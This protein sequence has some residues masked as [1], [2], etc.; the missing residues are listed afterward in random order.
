MYSLR[1]ICHPLKLKILPGFSLLEVGTSSFHLSVLFASP[2]SVYVR[3]VS[4]WSSLFFGRPLV[5]SVALWLSVWLRIS[6]SDFSMRESMCC[7]HF[8]I[9]AFDSADS[10]MSH[11]V[12]GVVLRCHPRNKSA[13]THSQCVSWFGVHRSRRE[14]RWCNST[15]VCGKVPHL[16]AAMFKYLFRTSTIWFCH[17]APKM[18]DGQCLI[19][20]VV[21][22]RTSRFQSW[23]GVKD[24]SGEQREHRLAFCRES[25]YGCS[26]LFAGE[27]LLKTGKESVLA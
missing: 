22:Y 10:G 3:S 18:L 9:S 4:C 27:M 17:C 26:Y 13:A 8:T 12:P 6:W 20:E 11:L 15:N 24:N 19:R 1:C 23:T 14:A 5:V 25:H 2:V 7:M 21:P 16:F